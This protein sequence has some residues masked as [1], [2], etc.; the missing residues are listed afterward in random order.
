MTGLQAVIACFSIS[1]RF[2]EAAKVDNLKMFRIYLNMYQ[3]LWTNTHTGG[4]HPLDPTVPK[5]ICIL[6]KHRIMQFFFPPIG[7]TKN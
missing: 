7:D 4:A 3:N 2:Q 6:F 5:P 1:G